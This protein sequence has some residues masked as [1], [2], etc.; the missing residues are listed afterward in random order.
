MREAGHEPPDDEYGAVDGMHGV[1]A[2]DGEGFS[3]AGVRFYEMDAGE[4]WD[5]GRPIR[6]LVPF[7]ESSSSKG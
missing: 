1:F 2:V 5:Q 3:C 7:W 6:D 4:E